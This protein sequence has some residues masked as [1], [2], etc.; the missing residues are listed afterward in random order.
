MRTIFT[1]LVTLA[2][3]M[4]PVSS[5]TAL[6]LNF[7]VFAN[8]NSSSLAPLMTG[9]FLVPGDQL[10]ISTDII[11][12]WSAGP[13][14]R[15]TNANGLVGTSTN[16]CRPVATTNY[17]LW[18]QGGASFPYASLVGRIDAGPYF[19]IGTNFNQV[20]SNTGELS[21]MF[22]DSNNFDNGDS[23]IASVNVTPAAVPEPAT[24]VLTGFG[25]AALTRRRLSKRHST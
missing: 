13:A 15:T 22:W 23:V 10:A 7:E 5:A 9:L 2:L 11:D 4:V 21:L 8:A 24:L 18:T 12:C 1:A 19:F 16:T 3:S 6:P 25:L 14:D 17:G 20:V